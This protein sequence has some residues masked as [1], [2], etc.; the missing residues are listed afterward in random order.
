LPLL[1]PVSGPVIA[2]TMSIA[3]DKLAEVADFLAAL[4]GA[5]AGREG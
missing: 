5:N 3:A 1:V 4:P 2:R